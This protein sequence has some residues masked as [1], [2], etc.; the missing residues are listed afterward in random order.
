MNIKFLRTLSVLLIVILISGFV[1]QPVNATSSCSC[2]KYFQNNKGLPSTG[3]ANFSAYKYA[4][5]LSKNNYNV[6]YRSPSKTFIGPGQLSGAGIII[7]PGIL[8]A[9]STHGHIGIVIEVKYNSSKNNWTIYFK[10]A[11]SSYSFMP[12]YSGLRTESGCNNVGYRQ[13]TTS[14]LNGVKFFTWSKK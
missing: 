3:I 10:D 1:I 6:S 12:G 13:I 8:G 11:N 14:S 9:N 5:W 2:L 7:N 4:D